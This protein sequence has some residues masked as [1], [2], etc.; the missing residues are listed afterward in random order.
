MDPS[1]DSA[2][3]NDAAYS[4]VAYSDAARSDAYSDAVVDALWRPELSLR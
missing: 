2:F 3:D 1:S 4:D